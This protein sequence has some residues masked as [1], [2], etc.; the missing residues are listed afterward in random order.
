MPGL[1][2][3]PNVI[4]TAAAVVVVTAGDNLYQSW[5]NL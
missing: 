5:T 4:A 1:V 3:R 2:V